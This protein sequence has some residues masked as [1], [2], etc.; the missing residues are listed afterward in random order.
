MDV[1]VKSLSLETV[2][3]TMVPYNENLQIQQEAD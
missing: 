3:F 2:M 1:I